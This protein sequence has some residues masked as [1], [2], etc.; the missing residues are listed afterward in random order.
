MP[1]DNQ[2]I[3]GAGIHEPFPIGQ[4]QPSTSRHRLL[5]LFGA[6]E[7]VG[8]HGGGVGVDEGGAG[9]GHDDVIDEVPTL[10]VEGTLDLVGG[11]GGAGDHNLELV[12]PEILRR[13]GH[14]TRMRN[15]IVREAEPELGVG[16]QPGAATIDE[17][18]G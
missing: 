16:R 5:Q 11:A 9:P 10:E 4:Q 2:S 15:R 3:P 1:S 18:V 14:E 12:V 13:T 8:Q 6:E 7:P 17:F